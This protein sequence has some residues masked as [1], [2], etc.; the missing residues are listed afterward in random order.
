[1]I[2]LVLICRKL[3]AIYCNCSETVTENK[4][5]VGVCLAFI[6]PGSRRNYFQED[7]GLSSGLDQIFS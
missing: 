6:L 4:N 1:M 3:S 5:I 2:A 7:F